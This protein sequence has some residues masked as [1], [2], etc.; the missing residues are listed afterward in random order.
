MKTS[1]RAS[2]GHGKH[3]TTALEKKS[4]RRSGQPLSRAPSSIH[5]LHA[6]IAH[7]LLAAQLKD[8]EAAVSKSRVA[9]LEHVRGARKHARAYVRSHD[10]VSRA[11]RRLT[12]KHIGEGRPLEV[13]LLALDAC[14]QRVHARLRASGLSPGVSTLSGSHSLLDALRAVHTAVHLLS[15][16]SEASPEDREFAARGRSLLRVTKSA[17]YKSLARAHDA[18]AQA[19]G[20][21]L[22]ALRSVRHQGTSGVVLSDASSAAVSAQ[23]QSASYA[24]SIVHILVNNEAIGTGFLVMPTVVVTAAH[25]IGPSTAASQ[26]R[27]QCATG[28]ELDV[29]GVKI[30]ADWASSQQTDRDAAVILVTGE[31]AGLPILWDFAAS[32]GTFEVAR[33][34]YPADGSPSYGTGRVHRAGGRFFTGDQALQ[35]PAGESGCP[36]LYESGGTV[37]A[38][39]IG[40]ARSHAGDPNAFIG[41]PLLKSILPSFS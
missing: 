22:R 37:S 12:Q 40:T 38:V 35:V 23:V 6:P 30:N 26:V 34:G 17:E 14:Y 21:A 29:N 1:S 15:T 18:R 10:A 7:G 20:P 31:G 11:G 19:L 13:E 28:D 2:F 3:S 27:V 24:A 41:I 16:D 9:S 25:V 39:G 4:A 32:G 36:L 33:Y 8:Q 5:Q